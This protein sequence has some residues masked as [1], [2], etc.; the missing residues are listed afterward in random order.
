MLCNTVLCL[1]ERCAIMYSFH[2]IQVLHADKNT[3]FAHQGGA[4]GFDRLPTAVLTNPQTKGSHRMRAAYSL[5]HVSTRQELLVITAPPAKQHHDNPSYRVHSTN[6][7]GCTCVSTDY[8]P[9]QGS[10]PSTGGG[11][12]LAARS[13]KTAR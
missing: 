12:P 9:A 3:L 4:I 1:Y 8:T 2:C 6:H 11:F 7:T 13:A 10:S 5:S